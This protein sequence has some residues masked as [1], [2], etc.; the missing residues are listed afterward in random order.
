MP[1]IGE[2]YLNIINQSLEIGY[3]PKVWRTSTITPI[4]KIPRTKKAEE[5]RAINM[6]STTDKIAERIVCD[7]I[8]NYI[9]D[10]HIISDL[11]SAFRAEHSCQTALNLVLNE[12]RKEME[13][14]N[15]IIAVFLD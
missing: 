3:C 5:F 14:G 12:W 2:S 13:E 8:K 6:I 10:N 1:T 4:P 9:N 11:Q 7:Q 15:I